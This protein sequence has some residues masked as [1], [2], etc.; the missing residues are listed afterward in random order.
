MAEFSEH[1][2]VRNVSSRQGHRPPAVQDHDRPNVRHAPR[3]G[4]SG[5]PGPGPEHGQGYHRPP[6][7]STTPSNRPGPRDRS[8]SAAADRAGSRNRH[9][10]D[11]DRSMM[12]GAFPASPFPSASPQPDIHTRSDSPANRAYERS[13]SSAG[14]YADRPG[15]FANKPLA[16]PTLDNSFS[17]RPSPQPS[18]SNDS[19]SQSQLATP[20][21]PPLAAMSS[22]NPATQSGRT[23]P[24]ALPGRVTPSGHR[25]RSVT[26]HMISE[27][28]FVSSTSTVQL[29]LLPRHGGPAVDPVTAPPVP[30]MNPRRR[31]NTAEQG[32]ASFNPHPAVRPTASA[33]P[34]M[35]ESPIPDYNSSSQSLAHPPPPRPRNR[36]RKSSSEGGNM[37]ARARQQALVVEMAQEKSR[38]P[39]V[40]VFPNRS[41]TSLSTQEGAMF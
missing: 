10:P 32:N 25:K 6:P 18:N 1:D 34:L 31:G 39:K 38:S 12:P 17:P 22:P 21:S 11:F 5:R 14:H 15:Y 19:F 2:R 13:G 24:I 7:R 33:F 27:P 9:V 36:L 28:T 41:A 8:N 40:A 30:A 4:W 3:S 16:P 35:P 20:L 26:K 37:A 23:T 29:N